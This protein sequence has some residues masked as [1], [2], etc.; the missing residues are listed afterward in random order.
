MALQVSKGWVGRKGIA[1]YATKNVAFTH[2]QLPGVEVR[3]CCHPTA[4]RP[5]YVAPWKGQAF[6]LQKQAMWW[7]EHGGHTLPDADAVNVLW[8][9]MLAECD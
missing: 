2:P 3:H 6:R 1:S 7:A 4:L 8:R 5:W 9:Q